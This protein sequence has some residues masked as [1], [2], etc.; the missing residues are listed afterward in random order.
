MYAK[1]FA[2]AVVV[3]LAIIAIEGFLIWQSVEGVRTGLDYAGS[4]YACGD[5]D[6][7]PC[8]IRGSVRVN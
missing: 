3:F 7:S 2:G 6:H 8:E 4:R 1:V 5:R